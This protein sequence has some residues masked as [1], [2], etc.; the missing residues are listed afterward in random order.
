MDEDKLLWPQDAKPI[1]NAANINTP[2]MAADLNDLNKMVFITLDQVADIAANRVEQTGIE[3][4]PITGGAT[5]AAAVNIPNGPAGQDA[6]ADVSPG[7]YRLNGGAPVSLAEGRKWIW[8]WD[9]ATNTGSFIDLGPLPSAEA[10]IK[11]W[12][13]G[14]YSQYSV[15]T[16]GSYIYRSNKATNQEPLNSAGD[17]NADW[18]QI[19]GEEFSFTE[20]LLAEQY[21]AFTPDQETQL[22]T[23]Q[24]PTW[25]PNTF[26]RRDGSE[27]AYSGYS[28]VTNYYDVSA[29]DGIILQSAPYNSGVWYNAANQSVGGFGT[30]SSDGEG[31][32]VYFERPATATKVRFNAKSDRIG[33]GFYVKGVILGTE[34][35]YKLP[36]LVLDKDQIESDPFTEADQRNAVDQLRNLSTV[37]DISTMPVEGPALFS[38]DSTVASTNGQTAMAELIT[39]TG[40]KDDI[41]FGGSAIEHQKNNYNNIPSAVRAAYKTIFLEIGLNDVS[42]ANKSS[43]SIIA[44]LVDLVATMRVGSPLAEIIVGT[45]TPAKNRFYAGYGNEV[46]Y[47][48]WQE[49]NAAIIKNVMDA[50]AVAYFHT[51]AISDGEDS[52]DP[53]YDTGDDLHQTTEARKIMAFSWVTAYYGIGN[54]PVPK[55]KL[56]LDVP[57]G[58]A[59][60]ERV[61]PIETALVDFNDIN[62]EKLFGIK[63]KEVLDPP[64]INGVTPEIGILTS[65]NGFEPYSGDDSRIYVTY[66]N[67]PLT[68][69]GKVGTK[70]AMDF[71]RIGGDANSRSNLLGITADNQITNL[72]PSLMNGQPYALE[73]AEHNLSNYNRISFMIVM[74][75]ASDLSNK[76]KLNVFTD[77]IIDSPVTVLQYIENKAEETG[78]SIDQIKQAL[79]FDIPD[80]P[81]YAKYTGGDLVGMPTINGVAPLP[82]FLYSNNTRENYSDPE[83]LYAVWL[84]VPLVDPSDPTRAIKSIEMNYSR[85]GGPAN[86][87]SNLL[88]ITAGNTIT[89]LIPSVSDG[90]PYY[91]EH[92]KTN[93]TG[94]QRISFA[95]IYKPNTPTPEPFHITFY[96]IEDAP[97]V[98]NVKKYIDNGVKTAIQQSKKWDASLA[99]FD[100]NAVPPFFEARGAEFQSLPLI[101]GVGPQN[102]FLRAN[103]TVENY[104]ENGVVY[105]VY[106]NVPLSIPDPDNP[107]RKIRAITFDH[108][109]IGGPAGTRSSLLALETVDGVGVN[110]SPSIMDNNP[111]ELTS[112][113]TSLEGYNYIS[114]GII[115]D[116]AGSAA[117]N[118]AQKLILYETADAVGFETIKQYIDRK[119]DEG[120]GGG[121]GS[122][123]IY[124]Q[125]LLH[126]DKPNTIPIVNIMGALP[127][128]VTDARTPTNIEVS[129]TVGTKVM[130][131]CKGKLS[132]Q[133]NWTVGFA[134]KGYEIALINYLDED[135]AVQIGDWLPCK[136]FHI[137][138][139]PNDQM[140]VKDV[141]CSRIWKEV[142]E[143][144]DWPESYIADFYGGNSVDA[145]PNN[146]MSQAKFISDGFPVE[147]RLNGEFYGL[148]VWRLKKERTNVM[149]NRDNPNHVWL[150]N[151][152]DV[153]WT[154]FDYSD[155]KL[156]SP[157]VSGYVD[158][159][160]ITDTAVMTKINRWWTWFGQINSGAVSFSATAANYLKVDAWV[161][162]IITQQVVGHWDS[163]INNVLLA[164]WDGLRL[165]PIWYDADQ[166]FRSTY[167][168]VTIDS[169]G[170]L[171]RSEFWQT[172]LY[173]PMEAAI[174]ARWAYL[175][176]AGIIDI[177]NFYRIFREVM[178]TIPAELY[179]KEFAAWRITNPDQGDHNLQ[180]ILRWARDRINHLDTVWL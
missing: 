124:E 22:L 120:G 139:F 164:S 30:P 83:T 65:T 127:T 170:L 26:L 128:D 149:I 9:S 79:G 25:K 111:Y 14:T 42:N 175:R 146:L 70:L 166:S 165:S 158:A 29:Y 43:A 86:T 49:L 169:N 15:V 24:A 140:M 40:A 173:P 12:V 104:S 50:D 177:K 80:V 36:W 64:V 97:E 61:V 147:F 69:S 68:A 87:R 58:A 151:E 35:K 152:D 119:T 47:K 1:S 130:F 75:K 31:F 144:R 72:V 66:R 131:R 82:G 89:N 106:Q 23:V 100:S 148:Y 150:D 67:V 153:S 110:L 116:T 39:V 13:A 159:G 6:K 113:T 132:I 121:E 10:K 3:R 7:W 78:Y 125:E 176:E 71:F 95:V 59:S 4:K 91:L 34:G 84:D 18:N 155:W 92:I 41:S 162:F 56:D 160:P 108:M 134:K 135:L 57:G 37:M 85:I 167:G 44:A 52:L 60:H 77:D 112:L 157:R 17:P 114:F 21:G 76:F 123:R 154:T 117:V 63:G 178:G 98:P 107:D 99:G 16:V 156:R 180:G 74:V 90:Q 53:K 101:N 55:I 105:A 109:A 179:K 126:I 51:Q 19:G 161:D 46:S 102:G 103:N 122:G 2:I 141:A 163:Q 73:H 168:P 32:D 38:G 5:S 28:Y 45:M 94:Y 54:K 142:R 172:K 81:I 174:K 33:A 93:L 143:S 115:Y 96:E 137:K 20:D 138:A 118:E 129:F 62:K 145:N 27:E 11:P 136:E 8:W 171:W 88:G 48:K 133:G